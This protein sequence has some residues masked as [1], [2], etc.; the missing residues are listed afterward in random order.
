MAESAV[1]KTSVQHAV[2]EV[3]L[4]LAILEA[5]QKLGYDNTIKCILW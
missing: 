3:T 4:N 2:E 5:V 1:D